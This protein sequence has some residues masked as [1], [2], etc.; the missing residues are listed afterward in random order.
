MSIGQLKINAIRLVGGAAVLDYLNTC[1]GRRPGTGL[2]EAV[3]KLSNLEDIVH[4]FFHAGIIDAQ[5]HQHCMAVVG[6][7]SWHTLTAFQQLIDFREALYRLLL[8]IALDHD[9][10]PASLHGLNRALADT[11]DQRLLVLTPAGV[12]WRWRVGEDLSSMTAGFIG[13]LAVQAAT[14]LTSGDMARLKACA[15][16]DCDWLFLDTSKNGRRRWCQMNI[17]GARE[18]IKRASAE[19]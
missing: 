14:L 19:S 12:I 16:P 5:E 7:S 6:R 2:R 3:D 9:T 8:P 15:T 11:A 4:W 10:D 17:C 1:D 13:R 18:K